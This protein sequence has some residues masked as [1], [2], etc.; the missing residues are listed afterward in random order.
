VI[1][2]SA[3]G[4][5]YGRFGY[6]VPVGAN[7]T[8]ATLA[9]SQMEYELGKEFAALDATGD[10][11]VFQGGVIHPFVRSRAANLFARLSFEEKRLEDRTGVV[12]FESDKRIQSWVAGL[13]YERRDALLGGGYSSV[14]ITVVL[15]ELDIRS[16]A[17]LTFDQSAFGRQTNGSFTKYG[18]QLSRL[19]FV[20]AQSHVFIGLTG[21]FANKNL[22]SAEKIALGGPRAVRAYP[23]SEGLVDDGHVLNAEYRY[24]IGPDFTVLGFYDWGWGDAAIDPLPGEVGNSVRLRGYGLGIFWTGPQRL[25]LRATVAWRDS[26]RPTSDSADPVPRIFA[27]VSKAF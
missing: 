12:N 13:A 26:G 1:Y 27:Q 3:G 22:D 21:Q 10:A 9:L 16:P 5:V 11:T 4:L 24:S 15:G 17:D 20:T 19:N 25:L 7:G 18:Y 8:R 23:V 6:E 14:G 2:G